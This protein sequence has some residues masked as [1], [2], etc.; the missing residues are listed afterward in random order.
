MY[1]GNAFLA[2]M[3]FGKGNKQEFNLLIDTGSTWTWVN[4]CMDE[5]DDCPPYF[6]D[7]HK[8][9]ENH[10]CTENRKRIVYGM[11]SI[12]GQ[13][14]NGLIELSGVDDKFSVKM[15]FIARDVDPYER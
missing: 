9:P 12:D 11:G 13:I 8:D 7:I 2:R 4:T 5:D 14:C 3:S 15:P 10:D 1:N 6:F